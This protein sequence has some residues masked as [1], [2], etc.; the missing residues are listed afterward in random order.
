MQRKP[1]TYL[2]QLTRT[3]LLLH[4]GVR[5]SCCCCWWYTVAAAAFNLLLLQLPTAASSAGAGQPLLHTHAAAVPAV[6]S[7]P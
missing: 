5:A 3:Q 1:N 7:M 6:P 2:M 4:K